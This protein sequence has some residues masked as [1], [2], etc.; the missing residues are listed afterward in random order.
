[1]LPCR[2]VGTLRTD[3]REKG[4]RELNRLKA[5]SRI[6]MGRCQ[7]RMCGRAAAELLAT[8]RDAELAS[9]GRLRGQPPVKPIPMIPELLS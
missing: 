2:T 8:T 3:V 6:G 4:A 7:G 5:F 9:A 1:M